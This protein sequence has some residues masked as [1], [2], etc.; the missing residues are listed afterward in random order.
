MTKQLTG[1]IL[2][3][4]KSKRLG[5]DKGLTSLNGKPLIQYSIDLL[6]ALNVPIIIVTNQLGYEQFGYPIVE[7]AFKNKGPIGGIYSGLLQSKTE[8]N[9]VLS[10]DTP[11]VPVELIKQLIKASSHHQ[12]TIA[13]YEIQ[14]HPL[15]G[16]YKRSLIDE[17]KKSIQENQLKLVSLCLELMAHK[18]PFESDTVISARS[19]TNINTLEDLKNQSI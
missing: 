16:I 5:K 15:I 7:D 17:F 9:I 1:I 11:Y 10:C 4:G 18:V 14:L 2:A 19:F 3:G 13:S 8:V 6:E 12:L